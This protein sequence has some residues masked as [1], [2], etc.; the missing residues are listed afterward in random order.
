MFIDYISDLHLDSFTF[1]GHMQIS[2][3]YDLVFKGSQNSDILIVAGDMGHNIKDVGILFNMLKHDYKHILYCDGNHEHWNRT[4][5]VKYRGWYAKLE[6]LRKH[7]CD[8]QVIKLDG[9]YFTYNGINIGGSSMWYD[10]SPAENY[11]VSKDRFNVMCNAYF[12]DPRNM[13]F[14]QAMDCKE[15]FE[16]KYETMEYIIG[17]C[18]VYFSHVGPKVPDNLPDK[19][20]NFA[21]G[22][23]YF[24]GS[25]V[26]ETP[27]LKK[28]IYGHT[29]DK[30][31]EK[32]IKKNGDEVHLLC[33]PVGYLHENNIN[34]IG[35]KSFEI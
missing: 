17:E 25:D 27:R 23:F 7:I 33:N 29:H 2:Q 20:K 15:W 28:W 31:D 32:I 24:D 11:G 22:F 35:V 4:G 3:Y 1:D 10:F 8:H 9:N 34:N 6:A 13:G 12:P 19:Y 16:N 26:L 21:T 30:V 5:K 14:V 18:D